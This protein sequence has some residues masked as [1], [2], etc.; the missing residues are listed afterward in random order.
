MRKLVLPLRQSA[1][2]SALALA[3]AGCA[4]GPAYQRPGVETPVAFKEGRGEWIRAA[5]ADTLER[6]PWWALFDDPVLND[7]ASQVEVTN[8]DVAAAVARYAQARALVAE[9]R[10]AL[11]PTVTLDPSANR[12]GGR[13]NTAARTSYQVNIGATWEPDVWGRLSRSVASARAGEQAS[14]AD[15]EAAR[16]SA[17]G[18]LASD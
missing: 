18:E 14:F 2:V 17:Q 4:V 12:S 15:L 10:A 9:Q 6:G 5:P 16:L 8:Q 3:L 11:F 7:L 1:L 13:S